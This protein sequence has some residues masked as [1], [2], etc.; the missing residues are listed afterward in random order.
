MVQFHTAFLSN[1]GKWTM[2]LGRGLLAPAIKRADTFMP[3][4]RIGLESGKLPRGEWKGAVLEAYGRLCY[5][6]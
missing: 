2:R 1:Y 6:A 4:A 3:G 5:C